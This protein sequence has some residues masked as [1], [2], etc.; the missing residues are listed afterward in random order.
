M[1][2]SNMKKFIKMRAQVLDKKFETEVNRMKKML[3]NKI[4]S[5]HTYEAKTKELYDQM[6]KQKEKLKRK[7]KLMKKGWL[8]IFEEF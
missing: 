6:Q 8:M 2:K 5:P 4:V 1:N 3:D 7:E